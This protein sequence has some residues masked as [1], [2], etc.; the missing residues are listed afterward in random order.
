MELYGRDTILSVLEK[1]LVIQ[2]FKTNKDNMINHKKKWA[3]IMR[4][5]EQQ[6]KDHK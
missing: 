4:D 6:T 3:K 2:R 1:V 5:L